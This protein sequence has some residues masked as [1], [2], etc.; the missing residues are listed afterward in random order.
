MQSEWMFFLSIFS[1]ILLAVSAITVILA[2]LCYVFQAIGLYRIA[3]R[4]GIPHAWF[5]WLPFLSNWLL[6]SISDQFR[7]VVKN[8]ITHRRV[9]LLILAIVVGVGSG[10][11]LSTTLNWLGNAIYQAYQGYDVD[12]DMA[13]PLITLSG[14]S[15]LLSVLSLVTLVFQC[16]ALYDLYSSCS[17]ANNVL[18]LVLGIIFPVTVPFFLFSCRNLDIGMPPRRY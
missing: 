5:A 12:F 14:L 18:F 2:I 1:S 4:R 17:P 9:I 11:T 3:K 10:V 13:F 7:Y 16:M 6:G 15:S 8:K